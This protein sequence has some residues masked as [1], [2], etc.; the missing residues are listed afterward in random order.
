MP[1]V[2]QGPGGLLDATLVDLGTGTAWDSIHRVRPRVALTCQACGGSMHAKV[3]PRGSRFFAHD[4][5]RSD[6]PLN[7]ESPDHRLLKSAVA[8]AV[9][10]AGWHATLE[11]T[12]PDLRWRADVLATSPDGSRRVAWEAQ[13]AQQ[14]DDDTR[15]RT[16]RYTRDGVEVVWIF[17]RLIRGDVPAVTIEIHQTSIQISA[18]V[19]RLAVEHCIHVPCLRYWDL[20]LAPPCPGHSRWEPVTLDLDAFVGLVCRGDVVRAPLEV[21]AANV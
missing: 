11:A 8:A 16:D 10:A 5:A 6:C 18:P 3:S 1:L 4:V 9:R 7:G 19:A 2:A 14:H 17:E 15:A 20:R 12:G 13:L 21:N